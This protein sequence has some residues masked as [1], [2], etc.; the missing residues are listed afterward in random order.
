M[1]IVGPP[2]ENVHVW[3]SVVGG[4]SVKVLWSAETIPESEY[5]S[6]VKKGAIFGPV[7]NVTWNES[8]SASMVIVSSFA[9]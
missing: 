1:Y 5:W 3:M 4:P 2:P 9:T 8:L 7:L 6:A